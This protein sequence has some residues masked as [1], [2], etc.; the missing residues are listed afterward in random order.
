MRKQTGLWVTCAVILGGMLVIGMLAGVYYFTPL[1]KPPVSVYILEPSQS[2]VVESGQAI[3]IRAKGESSNG[4]QRIVFLINDVPVGQKF[5]N[6]PNQKN[7]ETTFVW[8]S[9]QTGIHRV[10]VIAYDVQGS[11]SQPASLL[12]GVF[13]AMQQQAQPTAGEQD[14]PPT[15]IPPAD[16]E[17]PGTQGLVIQ[18]QRIEAD[19]ALGGADQ[20]QEILNQA[21][22]DGNLPQLPNPAGAPENAPPT[23]SVEVITSREG[24]GLGVTVITSA[25]DDLGLD[26]IYF[27][28]LSEGV[29]SITH[30]KLCEGATR[31]EM[32]YDFNFDS[33]ERIVVVQAYDVSG[34][35]SETF[36]QSVQ[37]A[38]AEGQDSVA[39]IIADDFNANDLQRWEGQEGD[40]PLINIQDDF[41]QPR[42]ADYPC[43]GL[44]VTLDVPYRYVS[45]HGRF[46]WATAWVVKDGRLIA[47]GYTPV[48]YYTNGVVRFKMQKKSL[49]EG[50]VTTNQVQLHLRTDDP[51]NGE[52]FY[53]ETVDMEIHWHPSLPD[54]RI[55]RIAR[56]RRGDEIF[57]DITNQGCAEVGSF[58]LALQSL[59]PHSGIRGI[60]YKTY[61]ENLPP[62]ETR[63]VAFPV[64]DPNLFSYAFGAEVDPEKVIQEIDEHNNTYMKGPTQIRSVQFLSIDLQD[65][66]EG[67]LNGNEGEFVIRFV[68]GDV[69]R[70]SPA[71]EGSRW[72]LTKGWYNITAPHW[73]STLYPTIDP[74]EDLRIQV[75][76]IEEDDFGN[77]DDLCCWVETYQSHDINSGYTWKTGGEFMAG[78]QGRCTATWRVILDEYDD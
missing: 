27:L 15:A 10:S 34:Q 69:S 77:M 44:D 64:P 73:K 35:A 6:Q 37:I 75:V 32:N 62:G 38:P 46:V 17:V 9:S 20:I 29:E 4:I 76:M 58:K 8:F 3:T 59:L 47:M 16:L 43:F 68:A 24:A 78:E 14:T 2:P 55:T 63:R 40:P 28:V 52:T 42:I 33:G 54:L 56:N 22:N 72:L 61:N 66:C 41:G 5:P 51:F 45:N 70:Y 18:S 13:S 30:R 74:S 71:P 7:M 21:E 26:F 49:I 31:C 65:A 19:R 1:G 50:L 11:A 23:L 25:E 57:I 53:A 67:G 60:L 12:L 48:E 39:I 36:T